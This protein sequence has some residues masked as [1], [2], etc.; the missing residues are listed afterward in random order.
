MIILKVSDSYMYIAA[1]YDTPWLLNHIHYPLCTFK[2]C[3]AIYSK[4]DI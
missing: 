1:G 3:N 2:N 4:R